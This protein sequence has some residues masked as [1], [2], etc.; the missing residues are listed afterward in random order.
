M[1]GRLCP[2]CSRSHAC[3]HAQSWSVRHVQLN[4][5]VLEHLGLAPELSLQLSTGSSPSITHQAIILPG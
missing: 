1:H 4:V 2:A 3:Q 5:Q